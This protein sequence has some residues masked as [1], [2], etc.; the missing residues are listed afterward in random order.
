MFPKSFLLFEVEPQK[1]KLPHMAACSFFLLILHSLYSLIEI[2]LYIFLKM[3]PNNYGL[4][5]LGACSV[6]KVLAVLLRTPE[7]RRTT[8]YNP[9]SREWSA[10]SGLCRHQICTWYTC[11]HTGKILHTHKY[12]FKKPEYKC[13]HEITHTTV[14]YSKDIICIYMVSIAMAVSLNPQESLPI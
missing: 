9:G 4:K 3:F 2:T 1:M 6:G 14:K 7:T 8:I 12:F 13:L 5:G 11:M 10:S